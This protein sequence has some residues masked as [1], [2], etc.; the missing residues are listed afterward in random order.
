MN[1][2]LKIQIV[3]QAKDV[4]RNALK[5][6]SDKNNCDAKNIQLVIKF[7]GERVLYSYMKDYQKISDLTFNE[8]LNVKLDFLGREF[9]ATPFITNTIKKL[10]RESNC[11]YKE[12]NVL[13]YLR[14]K[15]GYK[16]L[17]LCWYETYK[18]NYF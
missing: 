10:M 5:R 16:P 7:N 13:A 12:V 15:V 18:S 6:L 1:T 14:G 3:E 11:K 2:A 8:I 9:L 4:M 17:F